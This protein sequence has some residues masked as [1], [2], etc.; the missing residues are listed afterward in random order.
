MEGGSLAQNRRPSQKEELA[1]VRDELRALGWTYRDI[2]DRLRCERKVNSRVAFRLAHGLTQQEVADRWN[3]LWP[4][5]DGE[6]PITYKHISYWEAWP[7]KSGRTPSLK[8]LNRLA[9]IYCCRANDL[10]DGE[11]YSDFDAATETTRAEGCDRTGPGPPA[12]DQPATG[13]P[14]PQP[15]PVPVAA[16]HLAACDPAVPGNDLPGQLLQNVSALV[17]PDCTGTLSPRQRDL[18]FR[19]LVQ[20]LT[21]WAHAMD[22]REVLRILGWA[23]TA[24][25]AAPIFEALDPSEQDRV[26]AAV[27]N[28][29]RV[30][31]TVVAHIEGVLWRCMRQD[32]AI[33]PQSALDTVL[34]QRNL[35]FGMLA[36]CPDRV[37]PHLLSTFANLSRFAGWLSFDLNDF[38]SGWYYYEQARTAAHEAQ[39]TPLGALVL[40][41]MSHLATWQQHPR[42]GIDHAVAAQGWARHTGD[43]LLHGFSH[44]VAARAY[45]ME[46]ERDACAAALGR[47]EE[48]VV[49]AEGSAPRHSLAY[50]YSRGQLEST[51]SQCQ[52][53]LNRAAQAT[54]TGFMALDN[55]HH[56]FVRNRAFTTLRIGRA[57]LATRDVDQSAKHVGRAARLA[58]QNGSARLLGELRT[59]LASLRPWADTRAVRDLDEKVVSYGLA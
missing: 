33:G 23:A 54:A 56:S 6:T 49:T 24:A 50:F 48:A 34:A 16:T 28:P 13:R 32:D 31:P 9:R 18:A 3:E 35:A 21:T 15:A 14:D 25:S 47:A 8:T 7:T 19:Q 41:H 53:E 26:V 59:T 22:R 30:D 42:V 17:G 44:D 29:T 38:D 1:E 36:E 39:D 11:D 58:A 45:A 55:L 43:H 46:G 40:C 5:D 27:Q 52:L 37:R 10:L 20:F 51:R 4:C 12:T 57:Y 2:A